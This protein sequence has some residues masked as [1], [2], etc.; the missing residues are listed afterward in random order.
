MTATLRSVATCDAN[1]DVSGITWQQKSHVVTHLNCLNIQNAKVPCCWHD[2]ILI[3]VPM[4][5]NDQKVLLHLIWIILTCGMQWCYFYVICIKWCP[6][7]CQ[8]CTSFQLPWLNKCSGAIDDTMGITWYWCWCLWHHMTKTVK[9]HLHLIILT[10][11]M[12]GSYSWHCWHHLT[13][14]PTSITLHNQTFILHLI[15]IFLTKQMQWCHRWCHWHHMTTNVML[16]LLLI[17]LT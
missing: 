9:L 7:Q 16:H 4:T 6:H 14:T 5:S 3:V 8:C 10:Q 11:K 2:V 12:E 17:I 15:S 1:P 13:L